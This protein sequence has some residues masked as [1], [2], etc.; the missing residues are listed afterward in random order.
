M[1]VNVDPPEGDELAVPPSGGAPLGGTRARGRRYHGRL[2]ALSAVVFASLAAGAARAEVTYQLVP[3]LSLGFTDNATAASLRAGRV[4]DGFGTGAVAAYVHRRDARATHTLTYHLAYTRFFRQ[5][6]ADTV[7]NDLAWR[8]SFDLSPAL[9]LQLGASVTL[10]RTSRVDVGALSMAAP[11]A[12]VPGTSLF[13]TTAASE[14]LSYAF[15]AGHHYLQGLSAGQTNYLS[16]ATATALPTTTFAS[17]LLRGER[18]LARDT[19]SVAGTFTDAFVGEGGG[20]GT[21]IVMISHGNNFL[22]QVLAGWQRELSPTMT[23]D[24]QL[25]AMALFKLSGQPVF[26]PAGAATLSY[27]RQPWFA[28]LTAS[29]AP[30]SNMALGTST[31]TDQ[32]MAR[33]MLPLTRRELAFIA[34]SGSYTYA[35]RVDAN[36]QLTRAFDLVSGGLSLTAHLARYPLFGSLD[37]TIIDQRGSNTTG[38]VIPDLV[39]QTVL[40]SVGGTFMWGPGTPS[41]FHGILGAGG[42]GDVDGVAGQQR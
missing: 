11:Q 2:R 1:S 16:S 18:L 7:S 28:T 30:V 19:F 10:S 38:G 32:A 12:V 27:R 6:S 37:Y 26:A 8:S 13:L 29:Q 9:Q 40:I 41:P 17:A 31:I 5:N 25:G 23:S 35:R 14:D 15:D 34:A 22:A 4:G 21:D 39:R 36:D 24:V 42:S 3:A 33:L 20:T